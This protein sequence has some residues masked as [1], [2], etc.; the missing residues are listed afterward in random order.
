M[1]LVQY[2]GI[3]GAIITYLL[4]EKYI[5]HDAVKIGLISDEIKIAVLDTYELRN[6]VHI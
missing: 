5:E 2:G 4:K 6:S 1:Q 3:F